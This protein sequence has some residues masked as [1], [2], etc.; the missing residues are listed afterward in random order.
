MDPPETFII[1]VLPV[2]DENT[3]PWDIQQKMVAFLFFLFF[4]R[5]IIFRNSYINGIT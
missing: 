3:Q 2:G 4:L 1:E 5:Q